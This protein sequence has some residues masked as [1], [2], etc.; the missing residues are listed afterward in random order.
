VCARAMQA[1]ENP[2]EGVS[3]GVVG[4]LCPTFLDLEIQE[5]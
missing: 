3:M 2:R 4:L 1:Q 5:G